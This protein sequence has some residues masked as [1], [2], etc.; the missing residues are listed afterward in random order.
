MEGRT[1]LEAIEDEAE[2]KF[3]DIPV[4]VDKSVS[5]VLEEEVLQHPTLGHEPEEVEVA[6]EENMQTHL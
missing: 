3:L 5:V 4:K 6:A 2:V 1:D